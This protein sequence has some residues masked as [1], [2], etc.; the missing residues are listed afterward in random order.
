[1]FFSSDYCCNVNDPDSFYLLKM[2]VESIDKITVSAILNL[3]S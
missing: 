1:M 2:I 3:W